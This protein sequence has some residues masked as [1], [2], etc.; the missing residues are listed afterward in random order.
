MDICYP[1]PPR[2]VFDRLKSL[3]RSGDPVYTI[4]NDARTVGFVYCSQHSKGGHLESLAVD[5]DFRGHG[6]ADRLVMAL[7]QDQTSIVSLTTR[8]PKYFKRFGFQEW[9]QLKDGSIFMLRDE[10]AQ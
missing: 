9:T 10:S 7:L 5:P 3:Y 4:E 6:L 1:N 2:D 8:I